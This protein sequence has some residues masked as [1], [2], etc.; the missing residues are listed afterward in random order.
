MSER[1]SPPATAA[2]PL[3]AGTSVSVERRFSVDEVTRFVAL[4]GDTGRQHTLPDPQGRLMVHGLL[5]A[6]LPTQV[7]GTLH[8]LAREITYEFLRPVWTGE[9]VRCTVTLTGVE[10]SS[11]GT[12]LASTFECTNSAGEVVMRGRARGLVPAPSHAAP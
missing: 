3:I 4:S 2:A 8:F 1:D 10:A 9:T 5:L 6:A 12:R 7:G 11:H